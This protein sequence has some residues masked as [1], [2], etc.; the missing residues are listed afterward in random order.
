MT[1][2][3]Q[4]IKKG[5][6]PIAL[7]GLST[8][9]FTSTTKKPAFEELAQ[10]SSDDELFALVRDQLHVPK[11]RIYLNT[12]SLGPSPVV[13][14]DAVSNKM[15]QLEM[16]PAIE[17]WGDLG[18]QM[19]QVRNKV[20]AFINADVEN[21]ILTRNTTEGLSLISQSLKLAKGDEILTTT[22]EHGG[23]EIGLE[24]L[25]LTQGVVI[26]KL[27]MP[28]PAPSIEAVVKAVESN[29]TSKTKVVMLSHVNTL[30]GLKMP[31]DE[32]SKITKPKGILLIA[33]GAQAPGLIRVD[34]KS[35]GVDAYAASGHKWILGPKETGFVYWS[36]EL[37]QEIN[38]VF[39]SSGFSSYS[40]SSGTRNAALISGLGV[41]IDWHNLIGKE[42]I[43]NRC[44]ELKTYCLSRLKELKGI[45]I[46]S[47]EVG[48][49]STG[50]ASFTLKEGTNGM[51]ASELAKKDIIVKV[52][53]KYNGIRISCHMFISKPDIDK[54]VSA[55]S[56]LV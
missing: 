19:E 10:A 2:R 34:V 32:I 46:I 39:T 7:G 14:T 5:I 13:V 12:G 18:N 30:T 23:G 54:F 3:R 21:I 44:L 41:A 24:Y 37:Q 1:S 17:N 52:L 45:V 55:L 27:Q 49:L 16:N 28:V 25:A 31:F 51:I 48:S 53:P 8:I 6:L 33:D 20:A 47:P 43:E 4:F 36:K 11:G 9:P 29:I 56:T 50:I 26:K 38:P 15:R 40:A 22:H 35:M 42:K